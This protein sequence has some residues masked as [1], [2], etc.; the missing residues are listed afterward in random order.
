MVVHCAHSASGDPTSLERLIAGPRHAGL[1]GPGPLAPKPIEA[2]GSVAISSV[3]SAVDPVP[4]HLAL[5]P[6]LI[7][8]Q[9]SDVCG[10][11]WDQTRSRHYCTIDVCRSRSCLAA[12]ERLGRLTAP[13]CVASRGC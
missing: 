11:V 12:A 1:P 9:T 13:Q 4:R 6:L 10:Q 2:A 3:T 8:E 5:V 7:A